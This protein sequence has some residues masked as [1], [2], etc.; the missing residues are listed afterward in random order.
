MAMSRPVSAK[1]P[2]NGTDWPMTISSSLAAWLQGEKPV[3]QLA[4]KAC[5]S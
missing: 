4:P 1:T 3:K 2:L 5:N